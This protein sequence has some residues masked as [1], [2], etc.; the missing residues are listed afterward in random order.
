[1]DFSRCCSSAL[2]VVGRQADQHMKPSEIGMT[3]K[4]ETDGL[5]EGS[6]THSLTVGGTP[7][8]SVVRTP[9]WGG[10]GGW[11]KSAKSLHCQSDTKPRVSY[12]SQRRWTE[13]GPRPG[14]FRVKSKHQV[15]HALCYGLMGGHP[16]GQVG[17]GGAS[18][19]GRPGWISSLCLGVF[20]DGGCVPVSHDEGICTVAAYFP[21]SHCAWKRAEGKNLLFKW[22]L[23]VL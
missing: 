2:A 14:S 9:S 18:W 1:M 17:Q 12:T 11:G 4:T 10:W 13:D 20:S 23:S 15:E 21:D 5:T 8:G 16:F 7:S 19:A 6:V 22:F 3:S